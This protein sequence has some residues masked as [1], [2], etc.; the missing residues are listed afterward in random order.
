MEER[1]RKFTVLADADTFTRA[2]EVLHISQ[3]ALSAAIQKLERE[4]GV[5]L[6]RRTGNRF[7]LTS[8][9]RLAYIEG[10]ELTTRRKNLKFQVTHLK[11]ERISLAIGMIDSVADALFAEPEVLAELERAAEISLSINNSTFLRQ[12]VEHG[13]LDVAIIARQPHRLSS[14]FEIESLG[15]EPL[16]FV[17]HADRQGQ[18]QDQISQGAVANF[19]SYNQTSTTHHLILAAAERANIE[20]CPT[21]Y[22]T[23]PE[24]M[25][26]QVLQ[27]KGMAALP[28]LLVQTHIR[29][30]QLVPVRIGDSCVVTREV[31]S[32]KPTNRQ[33]PIA[34]HD[35]FAQIRQNLTDLMAS[36]MHY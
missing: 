18:L 19:L 17:V 26:R 9:G 11:H 5:E 15:A 31:V 28:Q 1:L 10:K 32:V 23:S 21:F 14:Q 20:L 16:V 7:E 35:V 33:L 12:A 4:L 27:Q 6:L 8:A 25:L 2:A 22:S 29:Q 30:G 34:I 24:I 3:P 36:A 13:Q